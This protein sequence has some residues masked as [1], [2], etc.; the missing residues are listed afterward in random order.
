[1]QSGDLVQRLLDIEAI[2]TLKARYFLAVDSQDWDGL[3]ALLTPEARI[4]GMRHGPN[5]TR[6][7]FIDGIR[8]GLAGVR[9]CHHGHDPIIEFV[10]EATARGIWAMSDDLIFPAGHRWSGEYQRRLGYGH[11]REEYRNE[12]DGWLIS[13]V[14]LTRLW[15][16]RTNIDGPL[17]T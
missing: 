9:T 14:E 2:K 16:W 17:E 11:Y 7:I 6:D 5:L 1:M 12:G 3:R 10:D 13:R 15:V 8:E 4:V